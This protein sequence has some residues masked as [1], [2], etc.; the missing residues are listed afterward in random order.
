[1]TQVGWNSDELVSFQRGAHSAVLY[2]VCYAAPRYKLI[3][4]DLTS[5][6][7]DLA[8]SNRARLPRCGGRIRG[9][10]KRK[11]AHSFE[12]FGIFPPVSASQGVGV[13][14]RGLSCQNLAIKSM[15]RRGELNHTHP[16][17]FL[18]SDVGRSYS[19]RY[20][21]SLSYASAAQCDT[22]LFDC[23]RLLCS[24]NCCPGNIRPHAAVPP[25]NQ[26]SVQVSP[27]PSGGLTADFFFFSFPFLCS[28]WLGRNK[29]SV[30]C[31][32]C[33]RCLSSHAGTTSSST[34]LWDS[35]RSPSCTIWHL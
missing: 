3:S 10:G 7:R 13:V 24:S 8:V 5:C 25:R 19:R 14:A 27:H 32:S 20:M 22:V 31:A 2:Q 30:G 16:T 15:D 35:L 28:A 6:A 26:V 4:L 18:C 21:T 12:N 9:S 11:A 29:M 34:G 33:W 23:V 1:M 17:F